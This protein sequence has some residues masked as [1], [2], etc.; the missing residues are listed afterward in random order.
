M[1]Y[2]SNSATQADD[3]KIKVLLVDDDE[4]IHQMVAL[5]IGETRYSLISVRNVKAAMAAIH[6][7][8]PDIVITDAMMPGESGFSLIQKLKSDARTASIPIILWTILEDPT[9]APMD[10]T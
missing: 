5:F 3:T 4:F 1:V 10:A 6:S 2:D 9:G 7:K 8:V